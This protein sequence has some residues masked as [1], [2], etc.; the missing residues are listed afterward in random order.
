MKFV[1]AFFALALAACSHSSNNNGGGSPF[2]GN[3]NAKAGSTP[4]TAHA[5]CLVSADQGRNVQLRYQ[6]SDDKS[7][8]AQEFDYTNGARGQVLQGGSDAGTWSAEGSSLSMTSN[9]T[10]QTT[11]VQAAMRDDDPNTLYVSNGQQQITFTTCD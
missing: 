3:P 9:G 8:T 7:Y 1:F 10:H 5:W 2:G 6:F 11:T 4:F